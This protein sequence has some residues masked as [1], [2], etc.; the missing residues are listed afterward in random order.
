MSH[1]G[2]L[3][4]NQDNAAVRFAYSIWASID[5][6]LPPETHKGDWPDLVGFL[7]TVG[8]YPKKEDCP[9]IKLATFGTRR[10]TKKDGKPGSYRNNENVLHV[11]GIEG[12]YDGSGILITP[13][14]ACARLE[15]RGIRGVIHTSYRHNEDAPRWRVLVPLA[16]PIEPAGRLAFAE[17]LNGL[18]SG[19][20]AIESKALS[21]SYFIGRK[22]G[23]DYR[24]LTTFDNP[25]DGDCIDDIDDWYVLRVPFKTEKK[26]AAV[27]GQR[28]A[29]ES[30]ELADEALDELISGDSVH[31]SAC[32]LVA[33]WVAK[34]LGDAEIRTIMG[35]LVEQVAA[36]RGAD[37]A[38]VLMGDELERMIAGAR[39][40]GFTPPQADLSVLMESLHANAPHRNPPRVRAAKAPQE[41]P[42]HLL[43]IPGVLG[44]GVQWMLENSKK[45]QPIYAVHAMLGLG[46]T[47]L[48]RRFCSDHDNWPSLFLPILGLSATGKES[49][50]S[51]VERILND[52][53]LNCLIGPSR[54]TSD[55]GVISSLI[56]R[57]SHLCVSD[58]FGKLLSAAA[59]PNNSNA[60]SMLR[61]MMEVW[62]RCHD[63]VQSIGYAT[64]GMTREAADSI[65]ARVVRKP[66]LTFIGLSTPDSFYE[67]LNRGALI[68]GFVNRMLIAECREL[69]KPS[70]F[71]P[72][73]SVPTILTDWCKGMVC[74]S[75]R[76]HG[77]FVPIGDKADQEPEGVIVV[78]FSDEAMG[79]VRAFDAWC[80]EQQNELQHEGLA[81]LYGRTNEIAMRVGL[82]VACSCNSATIEL[83]HI[84]WAIGYVAYWTREMVEQARS[85]VS[86]G[87]MDGAM[88]DVERILKDVGEAGMS[89]RD[90]RR[91]S[92]K[93][94]QLP[95]RSQI[96]VLGMLKAD[97]MIDMRKVATRTKPKETWFYIGDE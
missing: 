84:D 14:E 97:Q 55:S 88:K 49:I 61:M 45:P 23:A 18:F 70:I 30:A 51:S 2:T 57:P 52:S 81:E 76:D 50:K 67:S 43:T 75:Y 6:E 58:E 25:E 74:H 89:L 83:F 5:T 93:L 17:A 10:A 73:T 4:S 42:D 87:V 62:G 16:R 19:A 78:P 8:E 15:A 26:T 82:I 11:Y 27:D 37:R 12:D 31:P 63:T 90:L 41:V 54:Y 38:K 85:R 48:G 1:T 79:R 47:V 91:R 24:V 53:G 72:A 22:T 96:D 28:T 65:N 39:E 64:A 35:S 9:L 40:K 21:Q 92:R 46:A 60:R 34:G 77:L 13:E 95:P 68:D 94:A 71:R 86:D 66:A 29:E 32:H 36:V 33:R 20:L 44:F 56:H 7:T 59:E 3:Q 69:R 80:I